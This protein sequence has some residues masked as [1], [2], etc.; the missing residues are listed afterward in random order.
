MKKILLLAILWIPLSNFAQE[1]PMQDSQDSEPAVSFDPQ[2]YI[3]ANHHFYSDDNFLSDGHDPDFLGGGFQVN[4]VTIHH[5]KFGLSW[6]GMDYNVT[7][8]SKM[9]NLGNSYYLAGHGKFQYELNLSK[10]WSVEPYFGIGAVRIVQAYQGD[11]K[12]SIYGLNLMLGTNVCWMFTEHLG[13]FV[14]FNYN[15]TRFKINTNEVYEDYFNKINQAQIHLGLI[16]SV[17][18]KNNED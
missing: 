1:E 11:Q 14:G 8:I 6:E 15:K 5:I 18:L 17:N 3:F 2:F 13:A 7:D 9:G 12:R 10:N 4:I 16:I